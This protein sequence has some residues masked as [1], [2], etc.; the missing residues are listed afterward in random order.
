MSSMLSAPAVIPATRALTF[1]AGLHPPDSARD[2]RSPTRSATPPDQ[3]GHHRNQAGGGDQVVLIEPDGNRAWGVK[4]LHSADALPVPA[5][6]EC[7]TAPSSQPRRSFVRYDTHRSTQP[8]GGTR[9]R[10]PLYRGR[11][12]ALPGR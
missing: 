4:Q 5:M 2:M 8:D 10:S 3:P 9:L 6:M 7:S 1:T 11:R 12:F